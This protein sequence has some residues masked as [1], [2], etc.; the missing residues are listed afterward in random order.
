MTRE[1]GNRFEERNAPSVS[2]VLPTARTAAK[3]GEQNLSV[4][5]SFEDWDDLDKMGSMDRRI[6]LY[7]VGPPKSGTYS[8]YQIFKDRFRSEHEAEHR[9][10]RQFYVDRYLPG[11]A[12]TEET[13]RFLRERDERLGLEVESSHFL[14]LVAKDLATTFPDAKFVL[15]LRDCLSWL[16]SFLFY[17]RSTPPKDALAQRFRD[18][19][20]KRLGERAHEAPEAGLK[21]AGLLTVT[22]YLEYWN[23]HY[24][25][26]IDSVPA[27]RLLVLRTNEISSRLQQVADFAGIELSS[28]TQELAHSNSR[29][30]DVKRGAQKRE[31]YVDLEFIRKK[32]AEHGMPLMKQ[33]FPE[34]ALG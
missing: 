28:L 4:F 24:Q 22:E 12:S 6:R 29:R 14:A 27:S 34:I 2:T 7:S 23:W 19:R 18:G 30:E 9:V 8:I 17:L 16:D 26:V 13:S 5:V 1:P 32:A 20:F 33:Y 31:E 3:G 15:T 21:A 10:F 11:L 25:T